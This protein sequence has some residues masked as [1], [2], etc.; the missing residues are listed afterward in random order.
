MNFNP[1]QW[2]KACFALFLFYFCAALT[3]VARDAAPEQTPIKIAVADNVVPYQFVDS[4]GEL[5]GYV[6]DFWRLWSQK[7]GVPIEFVASSWAQSIENVRNG[8]ADIHSALA[9]N[10]QRAEFLDFGGEIYS[11]A[12]SVY[13]HKDLVGVTTVSDLSPHLVGM[14]RGTAYE[15]LLLG[16]NP[17]IQFRKYEGRNEFLTAVRNGEV[18]TFVNFDYFAFRYQGFE[19]LTAWFPPYKRI[20]VG[21]LTAVY[22]VRKGDTRFNEVLDRGLRNIS[23][24]ERVLLEKRWFGLKSKTN[25]LLLGF[26]TGNEPYMSLSPS[27]EATGLFVDIW[28]KWAEKTQT[29]IEFM[30]NSMELSLKALEEGK[31]DIHIAYPESR[32]VNT[33]LPRAK[34]LYSVFSNL[35]VHTDFDLNNDMSRLEGKKIGVFE[36][37]P[38]KNEF[39]RDYPGIEVVWFDNLDAMLNAAVKGEV[40][41]FIAS[42]QLSMVRMLQNNVSNLFTSQNA[43]R[44]EAKIYSIVNPDNE[45]LIDKIVE[46]FEL[47]RHEELA[48]L[49]N[50]WIK[51]DNAKY[52]DSRRN[53]FNLTEKQKEWL[54]LVP[55]VS[56]GIVKDWHPYEFVDGEGQPQGI[57]LDVFKIAE[58]MTGQQYNIVAYD[59]WDSLIDEFREGELDMVANIS[60]TENRRSFAEFTSSYW[61][62]PWSITTHKSVANVDSILNFFGK[63]LALIEEYQMIKDIHEQYPEV[64]IQVVKD[65]DEAIS[66]LKAGVID[67]VLDNMLVSA[68]YIQANDLYQFKIHVIEDLPYDTSHMGIR[69]GMKVQTEIMEKVVTSLTEDDR[70]AILSKWFKVDV[71]Q[72]V[73]SKIYL[74]NIVTAIIVATII[75]VLVLLWNNKLKQEIRKRVAAETKL[76]HLA[77]HDPLTGLPNRALLMD[78]LNL[79]IAGHS[80]S[81]K[82]L[83]LMF[84]DLDGFKQVN[85]G[86]GHDVGDEL[87]KLVAMRLETV[88]RASDTVA[89]FGGDEF[90]V[91]IT[92]LTDL[93]QSAKIAEKILSDFSEPF[94][95][96]VA[97]VNVGASIGIASYPSHAHEAMGL[98]KAADDAM[99]KV[100]EMGKNSYIFAE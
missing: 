67:G 47:I 79:A 44:Y 50:Q 54:E 51:D 49:E 61:H 11:A 16:Q 82:H 42:N 48:E 34:H 63:R 10:E 99:Y 53:T 73:S 6:V 55:E 18:K 8:K 36:T 12:F 65:Y 28:K 15:P 35:F 22:G 39:I 75:I 93:N 43:I 37:A 85:D 45:A 62:T 1:R 20:S 80:R 84:I 23:E 26:S 21:G 88:G 69:T 74:R 14:V 91:L 2:L 17:N 13:V 71:V 32:L 90:V 41:G 86:F 66:L 87:L 60:A 59:S 70:E 96:S 46:G 9:E 98:L 64:I 27:G 4:S 57:S 25:S 95:L 72:G 92:D 29:E 38:Y 56:V 76:K 31:S 19:E 58:E 94:D 83:A 78:R 33:G 81:N 24:A 68:Q 52:F 3:A 5:S 89:R 97:R 100:K 30:P 40:I 77:S 7:T